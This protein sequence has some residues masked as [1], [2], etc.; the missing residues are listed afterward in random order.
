MSPPAPRILMTT[1]AVGGVWTYSTA[2]ARAL[3]DR[4]Y[5]VT[6]VTLGP[7]PSGGQ[8]AS[9]DEVRGLQL[10]VTDLALE[11]MDP[12]GE[13]FGRAREVLP[14]IARRARPDVVHI[15]GFREALVTFDAPAL[16]VAHSCVASWWEACRART[17]IE[18]K[19][20]PYLRRVRDALDRADAW[21]A[22]SHAYRGWIEHFYAP[23]HEGEVIWNGVPQIRPAAH[24]QNTILAAGRSWDEAKNLSALARVAPTLPWPVRLAGSN[25]D[26]T[27]PSVVHLSQLPQAQLLEEMRQAAIFASPALYEPFGLAVLEAAACG[28]ALV[29]ADIPSFRELWSDAAIFA[30]PRD[31]QAFANAMRALCLD[32]A[33]RADLQRKALNRA[34]RYSLDAMVND[35]CYLYDRLTLSLQQRATPA[36]LLAGAAR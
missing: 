20:Q 21:V 2:L 8:L 16:V 12:E 31:E 33:P 29:L 7:A 10:Q 4:G 26:A 18:D 19:W 23:S 22:P 28:C 30:D 34:H 6:L 13:D 24:K 32:P 9:I 15:N 25:V 14:R 11:W 1:D 5:E 36:P 3:C 27:S 17:P 35:Y